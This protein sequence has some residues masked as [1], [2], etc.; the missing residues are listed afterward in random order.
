MKRWT[1]L[2]MAGNGQR[3]MTQIFLRSLRGPTGRKHPVRRSRRDR[4]TEIGSKRRRLGRTQIQRSHSRRAA[5]GMGVG[6]AWRWWGMTGGQ[7]RPRLEHTPRR[8][9]Q[10]STR[11]PSSSMHTDSEARCLCHSMDE[12]RQRTYFLALTA[13]ALG[14]SAGTGCV[15]FPV[16]AHSVPRCVVAMKPTHAIASGPWPSI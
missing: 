13:S 6:Q 8:C 9:S 3:S 16:A 11:S 2:P 14:K 15:T 1:S 7:Y 10:S 5:V 12:P 4:P